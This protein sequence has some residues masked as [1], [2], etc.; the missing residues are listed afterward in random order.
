MFLPCTSFPLKGVIWGYNMARE[1]RRECQIDVAS[2]DGNLGFWDLL[3]FPLFLF[4]RFPLYTTS[5][6]A[7]LQDGRGTRDD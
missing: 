2:H 4:G 6:V 1:R 3:G 5:L 7:C